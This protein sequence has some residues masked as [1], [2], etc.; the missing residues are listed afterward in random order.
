MDISYSFTDERLKMVDEQIHARGIRSPRVL[1]AMRTVPRHRFVLD[2]YISMAYADRPLP[3]GEGQTISQPYIV[4]LMT[5]L[6]GLEGN[7]TVLEIGTGSGY[8]AAILSRLARQ[9][10]TIERIPNLATRAALILQEMKI[11]NVHI[12]TGDGSCGLPEFSPYP[13]ILV[14]AAAPRVPEPLLKQLTPE[15]R[16]VI[17]VGM[18]FGQDLEVWTQTSTGPRRKRVEMVAFVPL[19]GK[20]GW[21]K[22]EEVELE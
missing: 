12:H 22:E 16:L 2:S 1:D 14:T 10:H 7:E 9:V 17:P 15:G 3:I 19:R 5:D 21:G 18:R 11:D 4:A 8:Q 6:L 13:A 20:Y